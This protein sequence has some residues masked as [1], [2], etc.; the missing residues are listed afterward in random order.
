MGARSKYNVDDIDEPYSDCFAKA[1]YNK[2][3][4]LNTTLCKN[5][6]KC[7]FYKPKEVYQEQVKVLR[8]WTF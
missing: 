7:N 2:C 3:T 1:P 4:A 5:G 8:H 6:G